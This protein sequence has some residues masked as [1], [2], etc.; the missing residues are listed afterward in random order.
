LKLK[1]KLATLRVGGGVVV[2]I[3]GLLLPSIIGAP[4][5]SNTT[6]VRPQCNTIGAGDHS[7][8]LTDTNHDQLL[9]I[10]RTTVVEAVRNRLLVITAVN[11]PALRALVASI[12]EVEVAVVNSLLV[13]SSVKTVKSQSLAALA[14]LTSS[15]HL[16]VART[17]TCAHLVLIGRLATLS[18]T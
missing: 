10:N 2:V 6:I 15:Q 16:M 9:A 8:A 17:A 3:T 11:R 4:L 5:L 7:H 1:T 13:R 18:A 14:E 12:V